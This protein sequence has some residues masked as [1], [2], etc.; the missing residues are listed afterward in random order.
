MWYRNGLVVPVCVGSPAVVIVGAGVELVLPS[1]S[2][3]WS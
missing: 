1:A 3:C 2:F